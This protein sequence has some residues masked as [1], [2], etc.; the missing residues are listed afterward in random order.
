MYNYKGYS[1]LFQGDEQVKDKYIKNYEYFSE[2]I[3]FDFSKQ[4]IP[5]ITAKGLAYGKSL[6]TLTQVFYEMQSN[7]D[8]Y[9]EKKGT[10]HKLSLFNKIAQ[11]SSTLNV[12]LRRIKKLLE[13]MDKF[14]DKNGKVHYNII[15]YMERV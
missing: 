12:Y 1:F 3:G 5:Y 10:F 4:N 14:R 15:Y 2:M 9:E 8:V 6:D 11:E 7:M 13:F